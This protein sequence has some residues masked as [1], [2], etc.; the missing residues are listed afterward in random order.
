MVYLRGMT[1]RV[2]ATGFDTLGI[3]LANVG[4]TFAL[5]KPLP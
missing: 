2:T 5:L 4:L 1:A 3:V